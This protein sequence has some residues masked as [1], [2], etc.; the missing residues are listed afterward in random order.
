MST[1]LFQRP[2]TDFFAAKDFQ[3]KLVLFENIGQPYTKVTKFDR[4][5]DPSTVLDADVTVI[6]A[7]G[8]PAVF[9]R[10]TVFGAALV[11]TLSRAVPGKPL[12]GRIGQGEAKAGQ[13]APWVL[14]DFTDADA[15]TAGAYL[16]ARASGTL[17]APVQ[18]A[19]VVQQQ[20]VVQQ[21]VVQVQQQPV[22]Q[23]PVQQAP[24]AAVDPSQL[25]PE[26]VALLLSQLGA[27]PAQAS[28]PPY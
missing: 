26:Q 7:D 28:T 2:S 23:A 3:G 1:D 13:S 5:D 25:S 21:P 14:L 4:P 16:T 15:Q 6:D 27:Q 19:P 22:A 12:L 8:G 9:T 18:Q 17:Q 10:S 11:G 20:P 24:A